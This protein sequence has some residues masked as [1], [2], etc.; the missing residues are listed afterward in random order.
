MAPRRGMGVTH[1][2]MRSGRHSPH[3]A[4]LEE[5]DTVEA[6][7]TRT[8]VPAATRRQGPLCSL[9]PAARWCLAAGIA[10]SAEPSPSPKEIVDEIDTIVTEGLATVALRALTEDGDHQDSS[11]LSTF[12]AV[13]LDAEVRSMAAAVAGTKVLAGLADGGIPAAVVKGPAVA[14]FHPPHWPR[15]YADIDLVI[16]RPHFV[17]AISCAE[18][19][20]FSS[21]ERATPQWRWF[22]TICREGINL[23]GPSGGNIDL[24]HHTPPWA[25]AE[26]LAVEAVIDRSEEGEMCGSIVRLA[27]P[28]DLIVF[29]GLHILND[30]WKGKLGL[31]SWR[32]V[33]VITR[34]IGEQRARAAF[35]RARV[36]WVFDL[37][38]DELANEV[39]SAGIR[40]PSPAARLPLGTRLRL[41]ALGWFGVST[42]SRHR[43]SWVMRLPPLNGIAYLAGTAVPS[44]AY[45]HERHGSYVNYW[46][47]SWQETVSTAHGSDF[48]MTTVGDYG[49]A[50][51]PPSHA[52]SEARPEAADHRESKVDAAATRPSDD[53]R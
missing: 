9:G 24:H 40:P 36:A 33:I 31:T 30:L 21:S 41:A 44:P 22:D 17:D 49:E 10:P 29:S 28:E 12:R 50:F 27:C 4:R 46:R 43:L 19:L 26:G 32:D 15:P 13:A 38:V 42:A 51:V 25:L 35:D 47:R 34:M 45:V 1:R 16:P 3:E 6:M 53:L 18:S 14:R 20:G 5:G 39:P 2:F 11:Y 8:G 7:P 23:H 52:A 37:L 48:R